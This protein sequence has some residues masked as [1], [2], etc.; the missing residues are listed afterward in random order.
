MA[1]RQSGQTAR[2]AIPGGLLLGAHMSIAGGM[3]LAVERAAAVGAS[4][5]QVFTKSS[6][7]W[8][9]RELAPGEA[10]EFRRALVR[11]GIAKTVA[12][13]SYLINLASPDDGLFERSLTAFAD[14]MRRCEQLGIGHLVFHPG[15]PRASGEAAGIARVAAALDRIH[16]DL[17]TIPVRATLEVTAGQGSCL[18]HRFEQIAA[19]LERV[20]RPERLAV[21]LDTCHLLAA[22]YDIRTERGTR[23]TLAEFDRLIGLERVEAIHL[24]DSKKGLGSRVDRHADIGE[25]EV[26]EA[27]FRVLLNEPRLRR[28]AMV[29]ETP[30][31]KDGV[32][33]DLRNLRRLV[34]L[35]EGR[36]PG[37]RR[38]A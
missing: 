31:G 36:R 22:G 28:A 25:G 38:P 7:Q 35:V 26:G 5:L 27:A 37:R 34:G 32:E 10:A 8:A 24:N 9:G 23:E 2:P 33:G 4:A 15:A 3:K 12:H 19:I 11:H 13:D 16:R 18:G 30:K 29:L 1:V 20:R 21:C 17:P 14:E 6:N